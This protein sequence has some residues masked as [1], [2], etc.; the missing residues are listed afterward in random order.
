M[1]VHRREFLKGLGVAG[2]AASPAWARLGRRPSE[3][4]KVL[5][6]TKSSGF[7]HSAIA[8]Q[9]GELSHAER[10]LKQ[11]G[12]AHGL[13]VTCSKDG[14]LFD[15]SQIGQWD[16][17]VFYTTGD[18]TKEGTDRQPPMSPEGL[19]AF[20]DAIRSG[21]AGFVGIHS[22]TDTFGTHRG[23]GADDPFIQ[24]IGGHF[25]GHG[26]QQVAEL[27]VTD[28]SFPGTKGL[29]R[30]FR[31]N[32]EWY[33]QKF[34]PDDLHVI[35]AHD[36]STMKGDDYERPNYPQTWAKMYGEGRVFYTSMG[37][38]ED[39]WENPLFQNLLVGGLSWVA[40][41]VEADVRPNAHEV[42]PEFQKTEDQ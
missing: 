14:R 37:H 25:N 10:I 34:Q 26:A 19:E 7:Q 13:N 42:T 8:R 5:F 27:I 21:R 33:S 4:K 41:L 35:I 31:L 3:A 36:T 1:S 32:D 20:L 28:P 11:L 17:F 15:P 6:F 12:E 30:R 24:M 18:L 39:V 40:G 23:R 2:L 9:G 16:A 22:A 38:R 29:E